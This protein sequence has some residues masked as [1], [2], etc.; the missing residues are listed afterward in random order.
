MKKT[1]YV[2]AFVL[3]FMFWLGSGVPFAACLVNFIFMIGL[4][5]GV[6]TALRRGRNE[7]FKALGAVGILLLLL[8]A[9]FLIFVAPFGIPVGW[10]PIAKSDENFFG[11]FA[12]PTHWKLGV[13]V[14]STALYA[15]A[16]IAFTELRR[17][18]MEKPIQPLQT[19]TGSEP[20][21]R[22]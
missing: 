12:R 14:V 9:N 15:F 2:V 11:P 3:Q 18:S 20:P 7:P 13:G 5:M 6:P 10:I 8:T 4:F 17:T 1:I 19:T 16:H 21:G 22:V